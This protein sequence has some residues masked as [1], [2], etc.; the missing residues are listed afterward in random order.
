MSGNLADSCGSKFYIRVHFVI[1]FFGSRRSLVVGMRRT[2][3]EA[4]VRL[5]GWDAFDCC[6]HL[7]LTIALRCLD[8][9]RSYYGLSFF[10]INLSVFLVE[11]TQ[12]LLQWCCSE[13]IS[14][15]TQ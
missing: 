2:F 10:T 7:S 13:R 1:F 6:M 11:P 5:Y 14:F 8:R 12:A 3:K 4:L 15:A 9:T